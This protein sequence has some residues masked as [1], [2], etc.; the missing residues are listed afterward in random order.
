MLH[1]MRDLLTIPGF[2]QRILLQYVVRLA[3][4]GSLAATLTCFEKGKSDGEKQQEILTA[5]IFSGA[6]RAFIPCARDFDLQPGA[7]INTALTF[8][9]AVS[10]V[11]CSNAPWTL[12]AT[13]SA[14]V[15]LRISQESCATFSSAVLVD[16]NGASSAETLS[17]GPGCTGATAEVLRIGSKGGSGTV[18]ITFN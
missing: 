16:V 3:I 10:V 17:G 5:L 2:R 15:D 13:P 11:G 4:C 7:N 8:G 6:Y 12:T 14:G 18:T 1:A 9:D